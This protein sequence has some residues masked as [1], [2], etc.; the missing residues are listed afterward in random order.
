M[1]SVVASGDTEHEG[2]K[3]GKREDWKMSGK[4]KEKVEDLINKEIDKDGV[5]FDVENVT[6]EEG[7]FS[8]TISPRREN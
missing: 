1:G 8:F 6:Q 2:I 7:F 3:E 5:K 4:I